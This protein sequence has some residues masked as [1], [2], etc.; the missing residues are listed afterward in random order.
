MKYKAVIFDL[1]GVVVTTDNFHYLAWK[2]LA[3]EIGVYFDREINNRLRGVS[4]MESLNIIL[5]NSDKVYTDSEKQELSSKKN[6]YYIKMIE[7]MD[8]SSIID[9][10]VNFI[11][12]VRSM[13]IKTAIG[14]SSKNAQRIL[15]K[16]KITE[17]F[18]AVADGNDIINSKPAPDVFIAAMKKLNLNPCE[19][20]VAEDAKAGV[21]AGIRAGMDVM[22][23]GDAKNSEKAIYCFPSLKEAYD[24]LCIK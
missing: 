5:E 20:L 9:G 23:V 21:E 10:A 14:S 4:R 7:N 8:E 19:C 15:R 22:A 12:Y 17:L 11:N 6:D 2:K 24:F 16:T 3:D 13:G 18:D 1:D